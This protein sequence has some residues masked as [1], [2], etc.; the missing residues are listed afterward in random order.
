[1]QQIK[2]VL[3][4]RY[5]AWWGAHQLNE[6]D[7]LLLD[8][9]KEQENAKKLGMTI[10]EY[11]QHRVKEAKKAKDTAARMEEGKRERA[12][13][14]KIAA[15]KRTEDERAQ[16]AAEIMA[17][18]KAKDEQEKMDAAMVETYQTLAIGGDSEVAKSEQISEST[19]G[20]GQS[21]DVTSQGDKAKTV[22]QSGEG[23]EKQEDMHKQ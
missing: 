7:P 3:W 4:E 23:K 15:A 17:A 1:M 8:R 6:K 2:F 9:L 11:R 14:E 20:Q 16:K 10:G 18:R 12:K 22:E 21:E 19:E 13:Q 5:R